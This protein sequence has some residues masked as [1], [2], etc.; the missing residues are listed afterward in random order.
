MKKDELFQEVKTRKISI[1]DAREKLGLE[2]IDH[3][4]MNSK[5]TNAELLARKGRL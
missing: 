3:P 4:L 5:L 2:R 1:N